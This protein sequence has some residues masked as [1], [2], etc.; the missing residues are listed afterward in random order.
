M[1]FRYRYI[2]QPGTDSCLRSWV[3]GRRIEK[4]IRG[5]ARADRPRKGPGA[6]DKRNGDGFG[7]ADVATRA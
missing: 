5:G 6:R 2:A 3:V 7:I 4:L 1:K